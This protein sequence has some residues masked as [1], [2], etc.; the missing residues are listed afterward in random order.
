MN[1]KKLP[2]QFVTTV[3]LQT[4][5]STAYLLFHKVIRGEKLSFLL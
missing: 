2:L 1:P 3:D 4:V 5:L